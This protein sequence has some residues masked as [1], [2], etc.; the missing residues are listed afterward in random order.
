MFWRAS[1]AIKIRE[2]GFGRPNR[3]DMKKH[4]R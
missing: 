1:I 4:Y 3:L 2:L